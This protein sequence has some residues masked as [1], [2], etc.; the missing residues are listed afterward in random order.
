MTPPHQHGI[1]LIQKPILRCHKQEA[2]TIAII[3]AFPVQIDYQGTKRTSGE[4]QANA[5]EAP[6][7]G[8]GQLQRSHRIGQLEKPSEPLSSA[9]G[10]WN[11]LRPCHNAA[12]WE[13]GSEHLRTQ[14]PEIQGYFGAS[15]SSRGGRRSV[16][17]GWGREKLAQNV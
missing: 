2:H 16:R 3:L 17:R 12:G 13:T 1:Q 10:L 11:R 8:G 15:R 9:P 14:S 6:K 7:A 5:P 4:K